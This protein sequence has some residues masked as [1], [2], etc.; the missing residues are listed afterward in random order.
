MIRSQLAAYGWTHWG[1]LDESK[2][3]GTPTD[4]GDTA[5]M[6][7]ENTMSNLAGNICT[8]GNL[9]TGTTKLKMR[10]SASDT[11][12]VLTNISVG[13]EVTCLNDNGTWAQVRTTD[14]V[15]GYCMKQV[16]RFFPFQ[17]NINVKSQASLINRLPFYEYY[18]HWMVIN[19]MMENNGIYYDL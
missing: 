15:T 10:A 3:G 16:F 4:D 9:K 14:G 8:P 6:G 17:P 1:E 18:L 13:D 19:D 5:P 12:D 11:A 7:G 2:T